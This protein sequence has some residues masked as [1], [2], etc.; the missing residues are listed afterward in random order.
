MSDAT[1][2]RDERLEYEKLKQEKAKQKYYQ[3]VLNS[4]IS[5]QA[6]WAK[7]NGC[8]IDTKHAEYYLGLPEHLREAMT[9]D[10]I[11]SAVEEANA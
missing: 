6:K 10:Q 4:K 1:F 3:K 7:I 11:I 5:L 9:V 2:T 8:P